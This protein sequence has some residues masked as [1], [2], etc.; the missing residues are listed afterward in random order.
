MSLPE[1][2]V[3]FHVSATVAAD[4]RASAMA[5]LASQG[6]ADA[7][8]I[9]DFI[10]KW[11]VEVFPNGLTD[12]FII[13]KKY[14]HVDGRDVE[15]IIRADIRADS[16]AA[17]WLRREP[18]TAEAQRIQRSKD[19][20]NDMSPPEL[21]VAFHVSETVAADV[22]ASAMAQLTSQGVA[23]AVVI[24]DFITKWV[25]EVFPNGLTDGFI[26]NKKYVHVD[27]RDVEIIIRADIR[28]DS[29]AAVWVGREPYT[30]VAQLIQRQLDARNAGLM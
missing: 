29:K 23:D 24:A 7:V 27:G 16:K 30:A 20:L 14:V 1:L 8:V 25:V 22:R 17:V 3:A 10:T 15:I 2:T 18:Y 26:I 28:A 13:N 4:V 11:V 21:I 5:Q 9:A 6:V 19:S 12:D